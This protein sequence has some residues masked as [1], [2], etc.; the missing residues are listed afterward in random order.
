MITLLAGYLAPALLGLTAVILLVTEHSLGLLWLLA[1]VLALMLLQ[2]WNFFGFGVV[3]LAAAAL[4]AV[5]WYA[6][7]AVQSGART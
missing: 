3:V 7:P 1:I 6:P 5:S 2:I 4:L